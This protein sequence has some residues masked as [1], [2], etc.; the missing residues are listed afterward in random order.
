MILHLKQFASQQD[1]SS[2]YNNKNIVLFHLHLS[3]PTTP[4]TFK[5]YTKLF[6]FKQQRWLP[7][8]SPIPPW[9]AALATLADQ[10]ITEKTM[11]AKPTKVAQGIIRTTMKPPRNPPST[12]SGVMKKRTTKV[13]PAITKLSSSSSTVQIRAV[14]H[15]SFG[16][17]LLARSRNG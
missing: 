2:T 9:P 16:C 15:L 3:T 17:A 4:P 7:L 11:P 10:A 8:L 1:S 13:A 5:S 14:F 6:P 12:T